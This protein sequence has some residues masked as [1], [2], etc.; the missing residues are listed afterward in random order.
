MNTFSKE[1]LKRFQSLL[2]LV[3]MVVALSLA[4]DQ[5]LTVPNLRNILLQISVNLCLSIGMTLIII[6]GGIDLSVGAILGL[7]GA[8]AAGLLKNGL[9]LNFAG[10][11]LQFTPFGAILAGIFIGLAL[12]WFNGLAITRFK[13][14]P[15]VA[16]L[17]MLS[18]GRGLTMLWTNGF[19]IT[20]LG[21]TFGFIGAG[22]WLGVPTAIWIS[23][24]LVALFYFISVRTTLGR[25]IYAVGGSEK[26][27]AFAGLNVNRIKLWVYALAGGL[28]AVGGLILTARLDAADPKA[29][30]GY[31]LDSIAAVVI[32]GTS[33]SGGRGSIFGTVLGCLIIGVLNNG[34]VLLE[35][36]PFWQQVIKGAVILLAVAVDK[37]GAKKD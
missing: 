1:N 36:S 14:P 13:L 18:I 29:G 3:V 27:A 25:Y 28:A 21:P 26:A 5:F 22:F 8:V 17:G 32:G 34:L 16:T 37:L 33:L 30:L 31:E 10:V 2:A 9:A 15:F 6:T 11:Q 4:S 12:G 20:A 23:A 35:V 19:P 7:S 24:A